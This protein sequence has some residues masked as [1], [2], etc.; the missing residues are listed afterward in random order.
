MR[1]NVAVGAVAGVIA[2][3]AFG[4][5]MQV[6][7]APTPDGGAMPM[8]A[9]V[10]MVVR[11][12]SLAA[13][14]VYHLFNSAVI[15]A[16]FGLALGRLATNYG[17]GAVLGAVYGFIWWILGPLILMPLFLGMNEM[18]FA[19][20]NDTLMSLVGHLMFGVI[21]GVTYVFIRDKL[22]G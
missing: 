12:D 5:M 21:T 4:V 8:M 16:I 19:I 10:A 20:N 9:M 17:M 2:G 6:M 11:S 14:W 22:R 3:L 1:S 7:T 13:G 15:G 18:M